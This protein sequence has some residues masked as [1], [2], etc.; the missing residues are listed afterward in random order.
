MQLGPT[1]FTNNMKEDFFYCEK[2]A[3][4]LSHD[5]LETR[6]GCPF[7]GEFI[8]CKSRYGAVANCRVEAGK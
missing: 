4:Q 8:S 3:S 6:R 7:S 1:I 5:G 2:N